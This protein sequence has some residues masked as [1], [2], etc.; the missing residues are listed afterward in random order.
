MAKAICEVAQDTRILAG[1]LGRLNP[2][3]LV[4]YNE[5]SAIIGRDVRTDARP[6]LASARRIAQ[7]DQRI[8]LGCVHKAGIKRL[9]GAELPSV[10]D[11]AIACIRRKAT[12]ASRLMLTAAENVTLTDEARLQLNARASSLGTIALCASAKACARIETA[13][14]N[15]GN[16]E[17]STAA[18]LAMLK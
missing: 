3:E 10:G 1:R 12:R 13:V 9:D 11:D 15:N 7:R 16:L 4:T 8:A 18:T 2:G 5:L 17:L 6:T 14:K